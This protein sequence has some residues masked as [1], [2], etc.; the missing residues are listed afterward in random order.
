MTEKEM[1]ELM[2]NT[3]TSGDPMKVQATL[4]TVKDAYTK[5]SQE[6]AELRQ[7]TSVY[8]EQISAITQD[9]DKV[10]NEKETLAQMFHEKWQSQPIDS[11]VKDEPE[12]VDADD[13]VAELFK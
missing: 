1:L 5:L 13:V 10:K 7:Q 3:L 11:K 9:R 12:I 2:V 6:N 8:Q 4:L